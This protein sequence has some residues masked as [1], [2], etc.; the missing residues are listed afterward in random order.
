MTKDWPVKYSRISEA[1]PLIIQN[2]ATMNFYFFVKSHLLVAWG[3]G[4]GV[5]GLVKEVGAKSWERRRA[6]VL[7]CYLHG[8]LK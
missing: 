2:R 6:T 4:A 8:R 1:E 3:D 7:E 5:A